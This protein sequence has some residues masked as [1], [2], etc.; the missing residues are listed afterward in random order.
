MSV[1]LG[2][3]A[4]NA[5]ESLIDGPAAVLASRACTSV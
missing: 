2:C 4:D 5:E 3:Q 1:T